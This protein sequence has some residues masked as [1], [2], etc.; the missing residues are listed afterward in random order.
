M[1]HCRIL[2]K[3]RLIW[4][5]EF[6]ILVNLIMACVMD[7]ANK[8]GLISHYTKV[9]GWM[10]GPMV[11]VDLSIPMVMSMKGNGKM[12]KLMVKGFIL[13]MMDRVMLESGQKISSMVMVFKNGLMDLHIKGKY[14]SNKIASIGMQARQWKVHM[15]RRIDLL[16]QFC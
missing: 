5:R 12:I 1:K 15:G 13:N 6:N 2:Q 10:I 16:R 4:N 7:Q 3:G 11:G 14:N 9:T 8:F